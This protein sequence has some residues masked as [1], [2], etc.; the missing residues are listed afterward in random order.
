M[1]CRRVVIDHSFS[2]ISTEPRRLKWLHR[3]HKNRANHVGAFHH[4]EFAETSRRLDRVVAVIGRIVSGKGVKYPHAKMLSQQDVTQNL[5]A[6]RAIGACDLN[7]L[8]S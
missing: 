6:A 8:A 3:N 5:S 4:V 2:P 7:K 1:N